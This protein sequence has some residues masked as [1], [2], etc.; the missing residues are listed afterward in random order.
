MAIK[1]YFDLSWEGPVLDS[2][3]DKTT[4]IKGKPM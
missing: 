4:E 1:T 3:G 2:A